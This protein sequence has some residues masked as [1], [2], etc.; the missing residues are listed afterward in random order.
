MNTGG[1]THLYN[2]IK[3]FNKKF[4]PS[5]DKIIVFGSNKVLDRLPKNESLNKKAYFFK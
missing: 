1:F 3:S 5:I 4:H 2:L